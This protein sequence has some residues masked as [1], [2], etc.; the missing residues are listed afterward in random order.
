MKGGTKNRPQSAVECQ[1]IKYNGIRQ[2]L[3]KKRMQEREEGSS[4]RSDDDHLRVT[5][6]E[7]NISK[8][9]NIK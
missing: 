8:N 4:V 2:Y 7:V 1:Q 6:A 3:K 5:I 9:R